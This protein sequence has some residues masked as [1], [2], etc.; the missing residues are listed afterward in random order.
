MSSN[1][2][3]IDIVRSSDYNN[4]I[5]EG[6]NEGQFNWLNPHFESPTET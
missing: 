2:G 6:G 1:G 5:N 4:S 3:N